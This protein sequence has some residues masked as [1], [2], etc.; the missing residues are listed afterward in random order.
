[1]RG[2]CSSHRSS[3]SG[4]GSSARSSSSASTTTSRS[5]SEAPGPSTSMPSKGGWTMLPNVSQRS[6]ADAHVPVLTDEVRT[7][8]AVTPGETVI[9]ATFGAGGHARVLA[10][11]LEGQGKLV[12]IDRDPTVK[13]YFDRF[14]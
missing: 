11:D 2:A 14:K 9:D 12:A 1:S 13:P 10:R 6:G 8:L 7:L 5:G 3:P 4:R